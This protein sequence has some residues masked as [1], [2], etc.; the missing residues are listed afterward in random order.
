VVLAALHYPSI[1][2]LIEW[3][4]FLFKDSDLFAFNKIGLI[5]FIALVVPF[6]L[7]FV[8]G[9]QQQLVPTGTRTVAEASVQFIERGII[10]QTIGPDGMRYLPFLVSLFF[11]IA[12]GNLFEIV[13]FFHMPAHA[14]MGGP[15]VY[16]ILTL[17]MFVAVGI[18]HHGA[19]YIKEVLFPPGVPKP[20]YILVT[21]IEALST[22]V[23]RPVSLAVR[24][25]ANMLAGHIL[26]V[27]FS[28]LCIALWQASGLA[29]VLAGTY[30]MLVILTGFEVAVSF[31]Q[32]FV[33]TILA[34]VYIGGALHPAH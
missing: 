19:G 13:P 30:P 31:L 25:F 15:M 11:F 28:V 14:R 20:I 5:H 12:I 26:L 9:R 21:P 10:M 2:N 23:I 34:A 29:V 32:A 3:P 1:E 6:L 24:L 22:F 8:A 18:K 17:I 33:F 7:F 4:A 27:T 16:G